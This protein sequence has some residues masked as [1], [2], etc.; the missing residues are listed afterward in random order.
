MLVWVTRSYTILMLIFRR[1]IVSLT[2]DQQCRDNSLRSIGLSYVCLNV[3]RNITFSMK[4][5]HRETRKI[6][7]HK[8]K[9]N[10]KR[11]KQLFIPQDNEICIIMKCGGEGARL[12]CMNNGCML[13]LCCLV[14]KVNIPIFNVSVTHCPHLLCPPLPRL[15][16]A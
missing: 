12:T 6:T 8:P 7:K 4:T 1:L 9:T 2:P 14:Y 10:K 11:C 13:T 15:H 3:N 5:Y 16:L